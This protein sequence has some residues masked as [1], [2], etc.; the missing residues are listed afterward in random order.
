MHSSLKKSDFFYT[1][2]KDAM[3][4]NIKKKNYF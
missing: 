2:G 1:K 4:G 3:W